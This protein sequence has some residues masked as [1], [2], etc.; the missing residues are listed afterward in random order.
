MEPNEKLPGL[1]FHVEN[2]SLQ[3]K[4]GRVQLDATVNDIGLWDE[5][6][7]KLDGFRVYTVADL[8]TALVEVLQEDQKNMQDGYEQKVQHLTQE[9]ERARQRISV[10]EK[11]EREAAQLELEL[12]KLGMPPG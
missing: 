5:V 2:T 3:D 12:A 9:L 8:Q 4:H 6:L 10:L 11:Y 1:T 7:K